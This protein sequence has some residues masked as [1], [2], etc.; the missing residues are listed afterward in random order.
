M[1]QEGVASPTRRAEADD[2]LVD[3]SRAGDRAAF[4]ELVRR[5]SR[6]IRRAVVRYT[7]NASDADDVVQAALIRA[8][9]RLP[10]FRGDSSFGTWL[11]RI[12]VNLALNVVR[13]TP[14]G[15]EPAA[16]LDRLAVSLA[17]TRVVAAQIWR[18]VLA[19]LDE[20]PP[21]QRVAFELRVF[22]E[23]SFKEI[24]GV[25]DCSEKSA[26]ANYHHA[27]K[28]LREWLPAAL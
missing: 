19:R 21:K 3:R 2:V 8:F 13:D 5:H 7:R 18:K 24:A 11:Y 20:L 1:T 14:S 9:E 16:Q 25:V 23:M 15:G 27:V 17:S 10:E 6:V 4:D 22:E 28:R 12:A 26:K